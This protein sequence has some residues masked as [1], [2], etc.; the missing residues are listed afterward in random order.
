M[1]EN[2][3]GGKGGKKEKKMGH[4][5][6]KRE[7]KELKV[8]A[9]RVESTLHDELMRRATAEKRSMANYLEILLR[10][11]FKEHPMVTPVPAPDE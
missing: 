10:Q 7:K 2:K 5:A 3:P 8:V 11:F 4:P 9:G 1:S 6:V